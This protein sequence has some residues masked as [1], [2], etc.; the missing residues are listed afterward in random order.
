MARAYRKILNKIIRFINGE[1]IR[2]VNTYDALSRVVEVMHPNEHISTYKYDML[3]NVIETKT[4]DA[5]TVTAE[6]TPQGQILSRTTANGEVVSYNYDFERLKSV[7]YSLHPNDS[8]IYTYGDKTA[9][10]FQKGRLISVRYP[11][12]SEEY[13]YGNM[14]EVIKTVKSIVI[15]ESTE[16]THT[17]TSEFEYDSWIR[18]QKMIYPDGEV[19]DYAY[20]SNGELKAI[21]GEKDGITYPYLVETGYNANGKTAFRKLGNGSE[22]RYFYDNKD[23]LQTSTMYI[24]SEKISVNTYNYDK[25][26]NITSIHDNGIYIQNYTYDE[27][28]RLVSANGYDFGTIGDTPNSYNMTMEY[29]KMSSPVV[30]NQSISTEKGINFT[31]NTY[32]YNQKSQPNAPIQIGDM[33]YTYDAAGNPTSILDASGMGRDLEWNADNQLRSIVDTKEGLFHSYAY[34]HTGERILKRYGT[35]QNAYVNGASAG[36]LRNST[37]NYSAYASAYFVEN[38]NGYTKHY[39]AG[40]TRLVSKIGE[41]YYE[42]NELVSTGK[43]EKE[44]YFYFQDHLGSSTYITDLNGEIAQYSAYTPYGEMFREYNNVTP[45]RFNGKELDTETGLY[46]YGARYYN[47]S[48]ALWLGVDPLASKYPGLSPYVYCV[49]N[50]VKYVDPDGKEIILIHGTWSNSETWEDI[51]GIQ[52]ASYKFFK[53]SNFTE[54][55]TWSGGNSRLDRTKAAQSLIESLYTRIDPNKKE[56]IT[57]VGHSHGGNVAIECLN[58]IA[59]MP[60]FDDIELNLITINT[61]VREDYQ[62]SEKAKMRV[63]HY[64]IYDPDDPI[65]I[66]GGNSIKFI[67]EIGKAGRTFENATNIEVKNPQ[68]PLEN[69]HNSHNRISEWD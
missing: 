47:P 50:P 46:Y 53:D 21:T 13:T 30:F 51:D 59:D 34:D 54:N 4:P 56:P 44:Q 17:Y 1:P 61:P 12:G 38:N 42:N 48:T 28:N 8:I 37:D 29:N 69:F 5:G 64:N 32:L 11:M 68:G 31:N 25:V 3:G 57:L 2:V 62:L 16:N 20:Y 41:D 19:V 26:D 63:N 52:E 39:Y 7:A 55:F 33:H 67:G 18:I 60:E 65:Q 66:I 36:A 24:G 23:R 43:E 27:L 40:A 58:L 6:Y 22:Q 9:D 15:D 49:G 45:Y 35:A 10:N 14:G